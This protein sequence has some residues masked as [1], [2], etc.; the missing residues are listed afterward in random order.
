MF[1]VKFS[2][3]IIISYLKSD[4]NDHKQPEGMSRAMLMT[5]AAQVGS[6]HLVTLFLLS[7]EILSVSLSFSTGSLRQPPC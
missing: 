7:S 1:Y 3:I 5:V 6:V 4:A 2:C